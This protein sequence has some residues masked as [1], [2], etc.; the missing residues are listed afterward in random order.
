MVWEMNG[1]KSWGER[2]RGRG[3]DGGHRSTGEGRWFRYP[4][5]MRP[6]QVGGN[7]EYILILG[8]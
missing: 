4:G 2:G 7:F 5:K 8:S 3:V 6:S 1:V